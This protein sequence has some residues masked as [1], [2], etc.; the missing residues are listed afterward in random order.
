MILIIK[1]QHDYTEAL[2]AIET[3]LT[4]A[5]PP[6]GSLNLTE[7]DLAELQRLSLLVE[8]YEDEQYPMP[9]KNN[10]ALRYQ[11]DSEY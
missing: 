3:L 2:A 8:R 7:S 5:G 1:T 4:K 11:A 6:G 9:K 10:L